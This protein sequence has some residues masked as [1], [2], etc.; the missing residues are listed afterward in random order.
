M[1]KKN[2]ID[3]QKK[4]SIFGGIEI[5]EQL[6]E[7]EKL[8][9]LQSEIHDGYEE[10]DPVEEVCKDNLQLNEEGFETIIL[11][12]NNVPGIII[13]CVND[14]DRTIEYIDGEVEK[15]TGYPISDFTNNNVRS[16]NSII[17]ADDIERVDK[18]VQESVNNKQPY[19]VEYRIV[20]K[21]GTIKWVYEKGNCVQNDKD[22][23][24]FLDGFIFDITD[25]KK[26][27]EKYYIVFENTGTS[28]GIFGE[29]SIITKCNCSFEKLSGYKKQEIEG[30]MHWYDFVS[31]ESK[32]RMMQYHKQRSQGTGNPHSEYECDF[33]KKNGDLKTVIVNI[34]MIPNSTK[35]IVSLIDISKR[36]STEEK[37]RNILE[38]STNLFYAHTPEQ[39]ITYLSPQCREL[40]QCEPEEAM[41]RWTEFIT[42]NPINNEGFAITK[43]AIETGKRQEPYRLELEGAK[44]QKI[45]VEVRETP[46]V[47]NGVTMSI[48]GSLTNITE[49]KNA[50]EKLYATYNQ[51]KDAHE[52]LSSVNEELERKVEEKTQDI[53][54]LIIQ[55]DEFIHML[56]HD[57]KNPMTPIFTLLPLVEKKIED[58]KLKDMIFHVIKNTRRMKN[59]IDETLKLARLDD[60]TMTIEPVKFL[61]KDEI[62]SIIDEN[63][64]LF[65]EHNFKVEIEI[66]KTCSV[67]YDKNQFYDLVSNFITNAVKYTPDDSV[68]N[69]KI[70]SDCKDDEIVLS[71]VDSGCGLTDE[72]KE[73]VFEKF[74]K[75]G[76]PREGM[77]SSGLGLSICK[78]I[79]DKHGGRI[80]VESDGPGKGSRFYISI[81]NLVEDKVKYG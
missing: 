39:E 45:W 37:L 77:T 57:L 49:R 42:D 29:D 5:I 2:E 22:E 27:E 10:M 75:I 13:R 71:F 70:H 47:K 33:M 61:L 63:M 68:G 3:Q 79:V 55:K 31:E 30:K 59:I 80:W 34:S 62:Q 21:E 26:A 15:I 25:R 17:H 74:Y 51:L 64:N 1:W 72:Q 16:Y 78:R 35:R 46:I 38:N 48:V 44:G 24:I 58:P 43:R 41:V 60:I 54:Q 32:K 40:L 73:N 11:N 28:M 69:L 53:N 52:V 12:T 66:D 14:K 9:L 6:R 7:D 18:A 76:T 36:K 4:D 20:N 50:E 19:V 81:K 65:N 8:G 23:L 56:G 67:Y